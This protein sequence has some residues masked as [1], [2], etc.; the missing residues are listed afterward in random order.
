MNL[1][2][3]ASEN[4]KRVLEKELAAAK[5]VKVEDIKVEV[6]PVTEES[7]PLADSELLTN[8]P[9]DEPLELSKPEKETAPTPVPAEKATKR[10]APAKKLVPEETAAKVEEPKAEEPKVEETKVEETKVEETKAEE[11]K[12]EE[13][14]AP[15]TKAKPK[16]KAKSEKVTSGEVVA[17]K[18]EDWSSLSASALSRKTVKELTEY[19]SNKGVKTAGDD[20]KPLTKATLVATVRSL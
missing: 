12:V 6:P 13:P 8:E 2:L 15:A 4:T 14:K 20:G 7:V 9:V 1:K 16:S 3:L 19:L 18:G 11:T 5:G 10:K 17:T